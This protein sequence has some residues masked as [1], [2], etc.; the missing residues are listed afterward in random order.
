ML[1]SI[2]QLTSLSLGALQAIKTSRGCVV[3]VKSYY[4]FRFSEMLLWSY[5]TAGRDWWPRYRARKC[6]RIAPR[7]RTFVECC[8]ALA[9][10]SLR[11]CAHFL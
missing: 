7:A 4:W 8:L 1:I 11:P 10:Y 5:P 9:L 3:F 2:P 6:E